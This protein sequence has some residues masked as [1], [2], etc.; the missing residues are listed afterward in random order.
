MALGIRKS[1]WASVP[2]AKASTLNKGKKKVT[3][4]DEEDVEA[5]RAQLTCLQK[6]FAQTDKASKRTQQEAQSQGA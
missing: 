6:K 5:L 3:A 4:G 1:T 2:T